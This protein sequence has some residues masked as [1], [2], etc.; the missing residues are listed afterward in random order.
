MVPFQERQSQELEG[1]LEGNGHRLGISEFHNLQKE[2]TVLDLLMV[3][4]D[5]V[6]VHKDWVGCKVE[7]LG[8]HKVIKEPFCMGNE[9]S[10]LY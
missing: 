9:C 7:V 5:L 10:V 3:F 8:S 4:R 2:N 6:V 1:C